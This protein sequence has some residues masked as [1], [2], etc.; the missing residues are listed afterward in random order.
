M[1]ETPISQREHQVLQ[2]IAAEKTSCE[3]SQILSISI[4]T[5][6]SH[7]KNIMLKLRAKN[8]AGLIRRAFEIGLL[9][10]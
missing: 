1:T 7:R 6:R 8:S 5:T 4:E 9:H 3:I 2:L 10:I